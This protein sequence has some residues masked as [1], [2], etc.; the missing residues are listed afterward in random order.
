MSAD[1]LCSWRRMRKA[2]HES[3][4]KVVVHNFYEYQSLEALLLARDT[5]ANPTAWDKH[6]RRAAAS[7][8]LACIYD[9]PPVGTN[10]NLRARLVC[11]SLQLVSELDPRLH[12]INDFSKRL[13][14]AATP[15]A[16]WVRAASISP[17]Q[18]LNVSQV[19]MMP[20]MRYIPS[21]LAAWK[22]R[23][24]ESRK[25][26]G[27]VFSRLYGHVQGNIVLAC[28]GLLRPRD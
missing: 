11:S 27:D 26:D 1:K 12:Q 3:L 17:M 4:N 25:K 13:T 20:W 21:R 9:E 6:I 22:R 2:G 7:M 10:S 18:L 28:F 19:E 8:V 5:L 24:M 15:G 16:H 23:A 14:R